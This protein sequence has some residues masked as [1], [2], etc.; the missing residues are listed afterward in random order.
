MRVMLT[1]STGSPAKTPL[2]MDLLL[3]SEA[4]PPCNLARSFSRG[5][6]GESSSGVKCIL[7]T[8]KIL[9]PSVFLQIKYLFQWNTLVIL[10]IY[11]EVPRD[12]SCMAHYIIEYS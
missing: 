9:S 6:D 1:I 11:Y 2:I 5:S 7:R 8:A 3:L 10:H 12:L 4:L